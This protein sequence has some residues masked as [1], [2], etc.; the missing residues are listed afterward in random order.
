[1]LG[2]LSPEILRC[3]AG[4]EIAGR[5]GGA[6]TFTLGDTTVRAG[7]IYAGPWTPDLSGC[8]SLTCEII[9]SVN[10]GGD[11]VTTAYLQTSFDSDDGVDVAAFYLSGNPV[12]FSVSGM[13]PTG[14]IQGT[15]AGLSPGTIL[16]GVMGTRF[17][18]KIAVAGDL[19][20]NTIVAGRLYVR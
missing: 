19:S 1:M 15:D 11:P 9:K 2:A 14:P 16:D 6:G 13:V 17:R 18:L 3:L 7:S 5:Q 8:R 4:H 12:L 20:E 10:V